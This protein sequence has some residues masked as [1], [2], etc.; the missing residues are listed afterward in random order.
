MCLPTMHAHRMGTWNVSNQPLLMEIWGG[1]VVGF[2]VVLELR[3]IGH[4]LA[5]QKLGKNTHPNHGG[6][7]CP[8][9]A[10]VP[11][12]RHRHIQQLANMLRDKSMLLKL[13]NII[14]FTMYILAIL[15]HDALSTCCALVFAGCAARRVY[16][17]LSRQCW[18][19]NI[20]SR[21]RW[22]YDALSMHWEHD[23]LRNACWLFTITL[24]AARWGAKKKSEIRTIAD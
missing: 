11:S 9:T 7:R 20:L 2:W 17:T 4:A 13:E 3:D 10:M 16:H 15:R 1:T 23:S 24:T 22:E 14:V 5:R 8:M 21:W 18:V 19:Y 6:S 12:P